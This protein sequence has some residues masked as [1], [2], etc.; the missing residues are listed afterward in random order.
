MINPD[1]INNLK[2]KVSSECINENKN[3]EFNN[4][5]L[6][7][8]IVPFFILIQLIFALTINFR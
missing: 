4:N 5:T 8:Y 2:N 7:R 6:V 1:N 3:H